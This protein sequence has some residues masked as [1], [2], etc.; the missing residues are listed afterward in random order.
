LSFHTE[1]T[2]VGYARAAV[3]LKIRMDEYARCPWLVEYLRGWL[4]ARFTDYADHD[5]D[6]DDEAGQ[7]P[8]AEAVIADLGRY[9]AT[10]WRHGEAYVVAPAM[11]AI[12]AAAAQALDL[13]GEILTADAAPTDTGV[14]LLPEPVYQRDPTGRLHCLGAVTWH[15]YPP[16][17]AIA[18]STP[19]W[20]VAGWADLNDPHD[21]QSAAVRADIAADPRLR[22][23]FGPYVLVDLDVVPIGDPLP[24]RAWAGSHGTDGVDTDWQCAPDGR[25][26]IDAGDAHCPPCT[27]LAYAFWRISAQPL[28]TAARPPLDRP[29]RRRAARASIVHDTRVVMLRRTSPVAERGDGPAKWH[30]RVRF[31]VRGHWRRLHD[32]DGR[33]YRV[34]IHAF[35]KGPRRRPPA[36]RREGRRA[37]PLTPPTRPCPAAGAPGQP[38]P[39]AT[40]ARADGRCRRLAE[41]RRRG[42]GP[43]HRPGRRRRHPPPTGRARWAPPR[44]TRR[45]D[46]SH[47]AGPRP[48][49]APGRR[50]HRAQRRSC[51]RP[52]AQRGLPHRPDETGHPQADPARRPRA[53]PPPLG[54]R[55]DNPASRQHLC[56]GGFP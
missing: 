39:R 29:A 41:G 51:R 35:I 48:S 3:D 34:W 46:A 43:A 31:A 40:W 38:T 54:R 1:T 13:T 50:G 27:A 52:Q 21:P 42:S 23:R 16:T 2:L 33:L 45:G 47:P 5:T 19:S 8:A 18:R 44:H 26:V 22:T 17:T 49:R 6:G 11:T 25:Y 36:A 30:Y 55:F 32:K 24:A 7:R 9:V 37:R 10:V 56:T 14:L 15:R 12:V 53:P 4:P 28:A 20:V